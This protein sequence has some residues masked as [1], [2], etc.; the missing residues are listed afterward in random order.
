MK[1]KTKTKKKAKASKAP[2]APH[3]AANGAPIH[4][5]AERK[6]YM[7][8][9]PVRIEAEVVQ[10]KAEELAKVI[11]HRLAVKE[12][13]RESMA[14]FKETLTGLDER[15]K[16]LAD[17]IEK[18]TEIQPVECIEY[19]TAEDNSVRVVRSDTGEEIECRTA[20]AKDRQEVL[21]L[22][23]D[24]DASDEDDP[25]DGIVDDSYLDEHPE[26]PGP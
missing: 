12:E 21:A 6:R 1:T 18:H 11:H 4:Q 9:L 24:A 7:R 17:S 20:E 5:P 2:T 3:R 22:E 23:P 16:S 26:S 19:L 13:R 10:V 8:D 25:D 14:E 15:E